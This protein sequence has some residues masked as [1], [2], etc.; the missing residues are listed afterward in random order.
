MRLIPLCRFAASPLKG[1]KRCGIYL[2]YTKIAG[3]FTSLDLPAVGRGKHKG[4]VYKRESVLFRIVS[5]FKIY[6]TP[7]KTTTKCGKDKLVSFFKFVL[8]LPHA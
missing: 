8:I 3:I 5:P 7:G 4:G 2:N 1:R 6:G